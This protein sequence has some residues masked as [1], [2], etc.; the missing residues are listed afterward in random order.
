MAK[1]S[2]LHQQRSRV[3]IIFATPALI[4]V[5]AFL[6]IPIIQAGYFSFT[7]WNGIDAKWLGISAYIQEFKNP[8][9]WRVLQNNG[10]LL[11]GVPVAIL[12]PM[13]IA[14][15]L[16]EKVAGWKIFRTIF[17]LPT[18]I[19]W[20]VIGMVS[21][22]F[23]AQEGLLNDLLKAFGLGFIKTDLLSSEKGALFA[24]AEGVPE[25]RIR[26]ASLR[27]MCRLHLL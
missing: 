23:F 13:G 18:A 11:L 4:L 21:M 16:N 20:V 9:F 15:L 2:S 6:G 5:S 14:F 3:G 19:S 1:K 8:I 17:F 26:C 7:E 22:R 12:F 27:G 24:V 10:L 25:I